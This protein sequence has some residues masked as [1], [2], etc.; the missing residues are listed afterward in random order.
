MA[1]SIIWEQSNEVPAKGPSVRLDLA[2]P[3]FLPDCKVGT[4]PGQ[5]A[6]QLHRMA[7]WFWEQMGMVA[8][9]L[10]PQRAETVWLVCPPLTEAAREFVTRLASF[11]CDAVYWEYPV[12]DA[13]NRWMVPAVELGALPSSPL[14][15]AASESYP[16]GVERSLVPM[17]GV[18]RVYIKVQ[19]VAVGAASARLHSHTAQDEYYL[20]LKGNGT[21]RL[22]DQ[23]CRV[24]AGTF[25]AKPSGPDLASH[26]IADQGESVTILD[27]EVY[28]DSGHQLGVTDVMAYSDHQEVIVAGLGGEAM[29]PQAAL[30]STADTFEHYF[31]GYLREESGQPRPQPFPGHPART[32]GRDD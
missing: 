5:Q 18:G 22:G 7:R 15:D 20:I 13:L 10:R 6:R 23:S 8:G 30:R 27:I 24:S 16:E 31:E 28:G 29:I 25:I 26:I 2:W 19:D 32:R 11:W 9:R 1:Q 21:L 14:W 12:E 3:L 17:L 4:I